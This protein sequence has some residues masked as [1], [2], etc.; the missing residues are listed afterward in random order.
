[1]AKPKPQSGD[2]HEPHRAI[3]AAALDRARLSE[4]SWRIDELHQEVGSVYGTLDV[5]A[6]LN[7]EVRT[8][9]QRFFEVR[10]EGRGAQE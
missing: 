5:I 8:L 7:S 10:L 1:M 6:D 2:T 4:L 3:A 9:R